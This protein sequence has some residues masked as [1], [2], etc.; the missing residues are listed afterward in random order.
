LAFYSIKK[1]ERN[2]YCVPKISKSINIS[3][4]KTDISK[5]KHC[6]NS[7]NNKNGSVILSN[8]KRNKMFS[9]P[10][11]TARVP[12]SKNRGNPSIYHNKDYFAKVINSVNNDN[13]SNQLITLKNRSVR[14]I[15]FDIKKI[16]K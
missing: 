12:S 10:Q 7:K 16:K 1:N 11:S 14:K 2:K 15:N 5:L 3:K 4:H 8:E 9:K 6:L 13:C